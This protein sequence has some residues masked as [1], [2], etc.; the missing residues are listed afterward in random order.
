MYMVSVNPTLKV[1]HSVLCL[2]FA[3]LTNSM[4]ELELIQES[5]VYGVEL[6]IYIFGICMFFSTFLLCIINY[7]CSHINVRRWPLVFNK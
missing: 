3:C 4:F 6:H 1:Y 2:T 7:L 5:V